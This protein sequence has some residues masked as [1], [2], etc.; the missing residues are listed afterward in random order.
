MP[1]N[2]ITYLRRRDVEDAKFTHIIVFAGAR[3]TGIR[4]G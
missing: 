2:L 4:A 3:S 1:F